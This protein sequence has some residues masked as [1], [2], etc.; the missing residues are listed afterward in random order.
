MILT[1]YSQ[2]EENFRRWG[3]RV[4][5]K[6]GKRCCCCWVASVVSDSVRPHRRQP[7]S[8]PRLWDSP[9]KNTG[10]GC[11]FL[12]QC[13]K[14]KSEKSEK[15]G[16]K[17]KKWE[18]CPTL[19]NPIDGSLPGSSVH[20]IS[21]ARV[22]EC[23]ATAFSGEEMGISQFNNYQINISHHLRTCTPPQDQLLKWRISNMM[24]FSA[25][26]RRF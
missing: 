4:L 19:S 16:K 25:A 22:L 23:V 14:V 2:F 13:R 5:R 26:A 3:S 12:L 7:T 17:W 11:H 9:G 6:G 21:Q 24:C 8:L 1:H 20:G 18:S 15:S 10:V